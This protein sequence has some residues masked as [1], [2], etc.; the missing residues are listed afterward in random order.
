M[1]KRDGR[2][3]RLKGLRSQMAL[4]MAGGLSASVVASLAFFYFETSQI[5]GQLEERSLFQ[6]TR[7]LLK[8]FAVAENGRVKIKIPP[9]WEKAY[10]DRGGTFA[11]TVF[12]PEGRPIAVSPNIDA[13]LPF[14]SLARNS[15]TNVAH[16]FMATTTPSGHVLVLS[17]RDSGAS[18]V[19]RSLILS[20]LIHFFLVWLALVLLAIPLIWYI[21]GW[22]LRSLRRVSEQATAIGPRSNDTRIITDDLPS[23]IMPLVQAFNGALDRLAGA[24]HLER[25]LT[26]DAAHELRTPIAVLDLRLQRGRLRGH[27]DW[28]AITHEMGQLRR[29]LD[30][31]LDLARK[32]RID[33]AEREIVRLPRLIRETSAMLLPM[34]EEKGREITIDACDELTVFG[35]SDNL[36]DMLRNLLENALFHGTGSIR[37]MLRTE[38]SSDG[39]NNP[40]VLEVTDEGAGVPPAKRDLVFERFSKAVQG[41]P[42]AGLGLAIVRQVVRMHGGTVSFVPVSSGCCVRVVLPRA[43]TSSDDSV[44]NERPVQDVAPS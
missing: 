25:R 12:D 35:S 38:I 21:I 16:R 40:V 2:K 31:M 32:D 36:R 41:S 27:I 7:L 18:A 30:Q 11:Y 29:L 20:H 15:Q 8:D 26:A 6:Q 17:R 42:G 4:V 33:Y 44:C 23:E 28:P 39:G 34:A 43:V 3:Y 14:F 24:Y 22:N 5:A 13:P 1:T 19:A 9:Q 37:V 10:K